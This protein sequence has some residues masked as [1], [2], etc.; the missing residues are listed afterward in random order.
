MQGYI[1]PFSAFG[2]ATNLQSN[3]LEFKI[4]KPGKKPLTL[5]NK[6]KAYLGSYDLYLEEAEA[7]PLKSVE[8]RKINNT[9]NSRR[10]KLKDLVLSFVREN[11]AIKISRI[12]KDNP[13]KEEFKVFEKQ[14][15]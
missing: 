7:L 4:T 2:N 1:T 3:T 8:R 13:S 11:L 10:T 9:A 14:L 5:L 15:E 12:L 6:T